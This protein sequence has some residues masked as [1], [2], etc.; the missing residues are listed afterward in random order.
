MT[1]PFQ[2]QGYLGGQANYSTGATVGGGYM[3]FQSFQHTGSIRSMGGI[4]NESSYDPLAQANQI[5]ARPEYAR[6]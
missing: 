1:K 4:S 6:A 5:H 2:N 3:G